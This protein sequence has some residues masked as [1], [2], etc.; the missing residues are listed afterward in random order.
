MDGEFY[1]YR[2]QTKQQKIILTLILIVILIVI[3]KFLTYEEEVDEE[4][5]SLAPNQSCSRES[6]RLV[7]TSRYK[8]ERL[9]FSTKP[10][11]PASSAARR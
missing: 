11:A 1:P 8:S 9:S 6:S 5:D 10:E 4:D 2:R 3:L 7:A